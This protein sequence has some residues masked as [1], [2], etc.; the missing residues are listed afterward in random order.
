MIFKGWEG[1]V[2][3][4]ISKLHIKNYKS[5]LDSGDIYLKDNIFAFIGQNN[6]GKSAI[7]DAIQAFFPTSKKGISGEDFHK[8]TKEDIV[9]ELWFKNVD[10][11]YLEASIYKNK[12]DK[13]NE[14]INEAYDL[15]VKENSDVNLKKYE[16]QKEKLKEIKIKELSEAME[17]YGIDNEELYIKMVTK[18]GDRIN[19]R[20]YN[21]NR[22]ELKEPDLKKILPQIKIIPALRDPK[23]ESTAG[24]NSYLKDLIQM[25]DDESKTDIILNN[26]HLTYSELNDVL[27][28]ETKKRCNALA[29]AI[30][31]YY[32]DAVGSEDYKIVIDASVNISKGTQYTTT[33]IDTTT[34]IENDILNCGTGYQSMII[35]SILETYVHISQSSTRYIL[36]IEEPEVYLHPHLQRKM[37]DTLLQISENNQVIFTSHSPITVS[38]LASSNVGLVEKNNGE[39]RVLSV[40][41]KK[42]IDELGIK[43]DDVLYSKGIIFVEGKD[44]IE[45]ISELIKK[46]DENMADKINIIQAHSCE[47]LKFYA[48][49][50]L[51][52][53]TNFSV[54]VLILRDADIKKPDV[55]KDNLYRE[56]AFT[57]LNE[58]QYANFEEK[59]L[60]YKKEKLK[61]SIYVL[62]EHSIEYYFVENKFLS[63]FASNNIELEYAIKCYECQ[64]R[65]QLKKAREGENQKNNFE[66]CFQ[67]KRFL[68]GFPD[69]KE[70]NRDKKEQSLKNRWLK[71]SASCECTNDYKIDN[72]LKVRDEVIANIKKFQIKGNSIFQYIIRNNDLTALKEGKLKE[73][74][75]LLEKFIEKIR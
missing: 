74:I 12:I 28:E 37:I 4:Y 8:D 54:P 11:S 43:P 55:L 16:K 75:E 42:V 38:K 64:Y 39:S 17:K 32:N 35:L 72:Y 61:E 34:G 6:T 58:P 71:L 5:F 21:K 25:L 40:S 33:I 19:K 29:E 9:I 69:A 60:E 13:Q 36:L 31:S 57:L 67:P 18:K 73:I 46:I 63:E 23:N 1:G 14:K 48:N 70:K 27:S 15:Y 50:E 47:N 22:E 56:I 3:M 59:E 49:A 20:Y 65:K 7:L 30:T 51:L 44:D 41:P 45:V 10:E 52:I 2:S 53:N 24:N 68:K 26:K 62:K 66:S